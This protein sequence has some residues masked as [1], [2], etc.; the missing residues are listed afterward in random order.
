MADE[1]ISDV[2]DVVTDLEG[3]E[4]TPA[5]VEIVADI[6]N[7][8]DSLIVDGELNVTTAVSARSYSC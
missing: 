5:N 1:V 8:I 6:F 2:A 4:Q 7:Q 3:D